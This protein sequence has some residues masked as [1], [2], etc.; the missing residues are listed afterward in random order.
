MS[1]LLRKRSRTHANPAEE[2]KN[3]AYTA[4]ADYFTDDVA[5]MR[6]AMCPHMWISQAHGAG[7]LRNVSGTVHDAAQDA[8][9]QKSDC[10]QRLFEFSVETRGCC[11]NAADLNQQWNQKG[12][13][14]CAAGTFLSQ[15]INDF[16][17][18]DHNDYSHNS[19]LLCWGPN[20]A[21][22][23][24][25]LMHTLQKNWDYDG[26]I[27]MLRTNIVFR[28]LTQVLGGDWQ[29]V[30]GPYMYVSGRGTEI[31]AA[32]VEHFLVAAW[33]VTGSSMVTVFNNDIAA[34]MD[35]SR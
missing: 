19:M 34:L 22:F 1:L 5:G 17:N 30:I 6:S 31:H 29:V 14:P 9:R 8:K 7:N 12:V 28:I 18:I 16:L 3:P 35:D 15:D 33:K 23:K 10:P 4:G 20:V 25:L 13:A 32:L 2:I 26:G 21:H 24:L 27:N 11:A